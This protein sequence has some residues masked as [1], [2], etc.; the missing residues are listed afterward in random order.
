MKNNK[1]RGNYLKNLHN[2]INYSIFRNF[3]PVSFT[4]KHLIKNIVSRCF[5]IRS[6]LENFNA[7][8]CNKFN[9]NSM[10]LNFPYVLTLI[11]KCLNFVRETFLNNGRLTFKNVSSTDISNF[12]FNNIKI[13]TFGKYLKIFRCQ[14]GQVLVASPPPP[15]SAIILIL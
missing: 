2:E 10:Y 7:D 15:G 4:N 3:L 1:N 6:K 11:V 9:T 12:E 13:E 5:N 14:V 8:K